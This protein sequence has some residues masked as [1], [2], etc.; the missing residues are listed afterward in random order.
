VQGER[1][2][3]GKAKDLHWALPNRS[4]PYLKVVQGERNAKGKAKDL[5]LT[6][7]NRSLSFSKVR[8]VLGKASTNAKV[9]QHPFIF[10][11]LTFNFSCRLFFIRRLR[12][13]KRR[14]R[15]L[16][17]RLRILKRRLRIK[18]SRQLKLICRHLELICR[19][20][21]KPS[22]KSPFLVIEKN[23]REWLLAVILH[24]KR[25]AISSSRTLIDFSCTLKN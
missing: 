24:V 2:A 20:L 4:L 6:F 18:K 23:A 15:I 13:L 3:K 21:V 5:F 9:L 12:I 14:L 10:S 11:C 8:F 16:K 19:G 22:A 7:P 17:R 1:N 25:G